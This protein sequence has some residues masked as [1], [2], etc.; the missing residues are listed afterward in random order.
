MTVSC[1]FSKWPEAT[2]LPDKSAVSIAEFCFSASQDMAAV[3]LRSL[4]KASIFRLL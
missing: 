3:M 2:A 1:L 4:I